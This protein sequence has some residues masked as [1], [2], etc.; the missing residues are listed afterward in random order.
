MNRTL[1]MLSIA[2]LTI[3]G[4][5]GASVPAHADRGDRCEKRIH[6]AE[7]KLRSA[8]ARHGENSRQAQKRREQLE[9]AR[10]GCGD[11]HD[12]DRDHDHN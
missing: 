11:R 4:M 1:K 3:V 12:H 9:N 5:V 8:V 6:K 7:E 2:L 10:R